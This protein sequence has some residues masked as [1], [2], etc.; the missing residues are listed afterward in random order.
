[1][2]FP[3]Y[4]YSPARMFIS[5]FTCNGNIRPWHHFRRIKIVFN[6]TSWAVKQHCSRDVIRTNLSAFLLFGG[7]CQDMWDLYDKEGKRTFE[8]RCPVSHAYCEWLSVKLMA[9]GGRTA[10]WP[11]WNRMQM[12][13]EGIQVRKQLFP[14]H[15]ADAR[16]RM[17]TNCR[18]RKGIWIIVSVPFANPASFF[19][20]HVCPRT[21]LHNSPSFYFSF[22]RL[23]RGFPILRINWM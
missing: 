22:Q 3:P 21:R 14:E 10:G 23:S 5:R 12:W 20:C 8:R 19:F 9:L 18:G 2:S 13:L 7:Y 6:L 17:W 15:C 1:M 11:W 4:N 16:V